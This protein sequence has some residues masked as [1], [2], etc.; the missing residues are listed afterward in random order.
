MYQPY[1]E[2]RNNY[3]RQAELPFDSDRKLMST[4]HTIDNKNYLFVKG[5]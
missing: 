5:G 3:P 4:G 1:Q 2:I